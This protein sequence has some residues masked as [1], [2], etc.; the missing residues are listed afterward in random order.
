MFTACVCPLF[1]TLTVTLKKL[2]FVT[3]LFYSRWFTTWPTRAVFWSALSKVEIFL[4]LSCLLYFGMKWSNN[5]HLKLIFCY[6]FSSR[7][8]WRRTTSNS[9]VVMRTDGITNTPPS[10]VERRPP[11]VPASTFSFLFRPISLSL[12]LS[13][14]RWF[15]GYQKDWVKTM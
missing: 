14:N 6:S 12:S 10:V 7:W 15:Y 3:L 13:L 8:I 1:C 9:E 5:P 2:L 11:S 4:Q